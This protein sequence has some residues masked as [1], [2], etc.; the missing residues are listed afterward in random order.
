VFA[1]RP[2]VRTKLV[3]AEAC[4]QRDLRD[5][6]S[7]LGEGRRAPQRSRTRYQ[8]ADAGNALKIS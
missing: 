6:I 1:A 2:K 8:A 7:G 4:L 3:V 5:R